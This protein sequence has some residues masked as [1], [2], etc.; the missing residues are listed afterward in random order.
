MK[1]DE[2]RPEDIKQYLARMRQVNPEQARAMSLSLYGLDYSRLGEDLALMVEDG[3]YYGMFG[4]ERAG[5]EV[6][7]PTERTVTEST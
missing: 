1:L 5:A 4:Q 2:A 3:L 7:A 6:P